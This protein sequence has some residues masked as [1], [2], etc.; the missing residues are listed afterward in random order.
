MRWK[1]PLGHIVFRHLRSLLLL[2]L[3]PILYCL[4]VRKHHTRCPCVCF[5]GALFVHSSLNRMLQTN[6]WPVAKTFSASSQ[7]SV[8]STEPINPYLVALLIASGQEPNAL[9][10][11]SKQSSM[12]LSQSIESL[13]NDK[14]I[15]VAVGEQILSRMVCS[16]FFD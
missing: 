5:R 6:G 3:A 16:C 7:L 15:A 2:G 11:G 8:V 12:I 13:L 9:V 10:A 1:T 4:L 14:A